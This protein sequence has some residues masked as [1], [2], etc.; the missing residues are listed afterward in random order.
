[1]KNNISMIFSLKLE[2]CGTVVVTRTRFK[3]FR[4]ILNCLSLK[5]TKD[6]FRVNV[7]M[8]F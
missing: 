2:V 1:M 4:V 7:E 5:V 6:L 8:K 3:H